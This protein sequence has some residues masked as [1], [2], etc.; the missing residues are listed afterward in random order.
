MQYRDDVSLRQQLAVKRAI[1]VVGAGVGLALG[2]PVMLGAAVAIRLSMGKPV[3]FRQRRPGLDEKP[4]ELIKF[5]TMRDAT[6][7]SGKPLP[8]EHRLSRLGNWLR[9]TSIDELPQLW[10]VLRGEM[11][12]IGPRPLLMQYLERY[13]DRQR[14]RHDMRPGMTGLAQVRGRNALS[15][16]EKFE[17]DVEYVERW[18]LGMDLTIFAET[19]AAVVGRRGIS[20]RGHATMPEFMG[21]RAS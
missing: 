16:E 1:D 3:F 4:F 7:A 13:N 14:H 17:L 6:D 8:D 12:L 9:A 10:N 5:R 19:V 21:T 11:S 18:S 2:W 15:W 20:Q